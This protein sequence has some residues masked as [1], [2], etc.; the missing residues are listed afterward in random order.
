MSQQQSTQNFQIAKIKWGGNKEKFL[1]AN[2]SDGRPLWFSAGPGVSVAPSQG[3]SSGPESLPWDSPSASS[4][5]SLGSSP[6]AGTNDSG[7]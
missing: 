2:V 5:G 3:S 7:V 1:S 4:R 6:P